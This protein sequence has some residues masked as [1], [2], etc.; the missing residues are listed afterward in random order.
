MGEIIV[1]KLL[2]KVAGALEASPEGGENG[3]I[4]T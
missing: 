1:L 2:V 3:G 4:V